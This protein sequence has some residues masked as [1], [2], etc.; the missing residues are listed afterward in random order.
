MK[1]FVQE[2][3]EEIDKRTMAI[4]CFHTFSATSAYVFNVLKGYLKQPY[5]VSFPFASQYLKQVEFSS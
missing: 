1:K 4:T 2:F 5:H 3:L